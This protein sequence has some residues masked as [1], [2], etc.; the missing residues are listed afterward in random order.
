MRQGVRLEPLLEAISKF[1]DRQHEMIEQV[2]RDLV[3]GLKK[4]RKGRHGLTAPQ[5]LRSLVLM[6]VK[7]WDYRE[8]R[9][10]IAD[11]LMLRQFTD[12]YCD[13]VPKHDAFNRGFNRLTPQTLKA[14]N[15][16]VV[17][18]AVGLGLEDGARLRVDT[19][20]VETDIHHPTDN[21]LLWDVVR[22]VTRLIGRLAEALNM[23]RIE[24]F[25]DRR[26]AAHRRMYEIQRMTTRQR[27]G[28]GSRQTATYRA[29]IDIA[30]E[31]VAS[32][33]AALEETAGTHGTDPFA[34]MT[35]DAVRDEIAHY[36]GLGARAIDQARR[37]VLD[38]EQVPNAEKIYSIFEPH[39]DL[40]KR[41]KVRTPVE[42]GHKVFLA[43]SARGL[44]TQY[45]VLKGNPCDEVHVAPSLKRHRRIRTRG[46]TLCVGSRFLQRGQRCML[47]E[48]RR[49]HSLHSAA[50]RKQNAATPG[51]RKVGAVQARPALSR[52]HR[53]AHLG[54]DAR[55]RHEALP[56]RGRRALCAV[57]WRRGAR[58]QPHDRGRPADQAVGAPPKSHPINDPIV[59]ASGIKAAAPHHV[60]SN[61][62]AWQTPIHAENDATRTRKFSNT[63]LT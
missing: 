48:R 57:R 46:G 27:Q 2:R 5:V 33:K 39:T 26:R 43:E 16:V 10:R 20:V 49:Q 7:N 63:A 55:S 6:R 24:G 35:I 47:R 40:I 13:P 34:A 62:F 12:F 8:L 38:G 22:V 44:I 11:G 54:T 23:R 37:R 50:R 60:A 42:F 59:V 4:P 1:L 53:R 29:L 36:C 56:R 3:R 32:A 45:E 31:V 52:R 51:L 28:V 25:R 14:V 61:N 21:T 9:E 19:T 15:D 41:G 58:Q 18:A 30:E 17:R